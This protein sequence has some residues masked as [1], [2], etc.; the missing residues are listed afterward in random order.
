M[1]HAS[2]RLNKSFNACLP[3]PTSFS[4]PGLTYFSHSILRAT[5]SEESSNG[6]NQYA[7]EERDGVV[8]LEDVPPAEKKDYDTVVPE[9]L[10]KE[11]TENGQAQTLT[12]EFL[13]NLSVRDS[14]ASF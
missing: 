12:F 14:I 3:L 8:T 10:Q 6:P 4:F 9:V 11:S 1:N 5:T 13:D 7:S 2:F